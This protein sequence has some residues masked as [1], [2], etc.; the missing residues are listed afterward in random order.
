MRVQNIIHKHVS[1]PLLTPSKIEPSIDPRLE[2]I[3]VRA[4]EKEPAARQE[5]MR[6]LRSALRELL[7]GTDASPPPMSVR[8]MPAPSAR[9]IATA[10]GTAHAPVPAEDLADVISA[11]PVA[12]ARELGTTTDQRAFARLE[13]AMRALAARG[14]VRALWAVTGVLAGMT[15]A[16]GEAAAQVLRVFQDPRSE[17]HTSELQSPCKLV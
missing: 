15:G 3:I 5:N 17:E 10:A 11:N 6:E 7:V 14:D 12:W 9:M 8:E 16:R 13:P 1:T 2:A 4:L